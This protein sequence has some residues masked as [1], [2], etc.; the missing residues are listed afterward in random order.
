M[1]V[2]GR[3]INKTENVDSNEYLTFEKRIVEQIGLVEM[4]FGVLG[5]YSIMNC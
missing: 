5:V 1:E 4:Y 2:L 3:A